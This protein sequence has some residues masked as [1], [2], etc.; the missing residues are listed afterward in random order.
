MPTLIDFQ[1]VDPKHEFPHEYPRDASYALTETHYF[2]AQ[3]LEP[4]LD[5]EIYVWYHPTLRVV[6][7]G[8]FCFSG[9]ASTHM[10]SDYFDYQVYLPWPTVTG[11]SIRFVNGLE[12]I[13]EEPL[14]RIRVLYRN[15]ARGV[16]LDLLYTAVMPAVARRRAMHNEAVQQAA[17]DVGGFE[18][19]MHVQ[20]EIRLGQRHQ[21]VD[22]Y[23]V[24]DRSYG[25]IRSEA[26][27][28]GP[29]FGWQAAAFD[30]D[31]SFGILGVE[32]PRLGPNWAAEFAVPPDKTLFSGWVCREGKVYEV[33]RLSR[34]MQREDNGIWPTSGEFV[35]EDSTGQAF[36]I[37]SRIVAVEP[38]GPW[39]NMQLA[40][41]LTRFEMDGRVAAG[42]TQ[43][44][45]LQDFCRKFYRARQAR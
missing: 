9:L 26:P 35:F 12:L 45:L 27:A 13:I 22:T 40:W 1:P 18:Q 10:A 33:K 23:F 28:S 17:Y 8:V 14:Q 20:G 25:Q 30:R 29:P 43:E 24:R 21:V 3:L 6:S 37:R 41:C 15:D 32:D 16:N 39:P 11:R 34:L 7:A 31:F 42:T 19:T 44:I 36:S 38:W 2:G 5:C 4:D